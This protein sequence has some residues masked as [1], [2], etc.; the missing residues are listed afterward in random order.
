MAKRKRIIIP[1]NYDENWTG[2][3]YYISNLVASLSL[4]PENIQPE[5]FILSHSKNSFEFVQSTSG[6]KRI[7]RISSLMLKDVDGGLSLRLKL[8][9]KLIPSF[10]KREVNF[11]AIFPFPIDT[12]ERKRTI[13]WI[14]DLQEKSLPHLFSPE[15][16]RYRTSQHI[17]YIENFDHILFSS[18]AA[19]ADFERYY[20]QSRNF[21]HVMSFAVNPANS[22]KP[23]ETVMKKYSLPDV[24]FYC[25]NQFWLHKNHEAVIE[26]VYR[27]AKKNIMVT[28]VFSGREMD[29]RDP[30]HVERL[31]H[32]VAEYKLERKIRFLGFISKEEQYALIDSA[33]ALLQPSLFEGWSTVIEEAKSR[34]QFVIASD[35]PVHHEQLEVNADFFDPYNADDLALALERRLKDNS[36]NVKIDYDNHRLEFAKKFMDIIDKIDKEV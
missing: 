9:S 11:D 26:A 36:K 24:F 10:A 14:P 28:V 21:K 3:N 15:E 5:I 22:L 34:S 25:P 8:L 18:H 35:I 6:Y 20:P 2:G 31:K 4:L 27:L 17:Y 13:C 7:K 23:S 1:F 19:L 16:L 29:R 12:K 33:R 32:K 30:D